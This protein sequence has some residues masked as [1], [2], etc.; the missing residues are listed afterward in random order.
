MNCTKHIAPTNPQIDFANVKQNDE[1]SYS[2]ILIRGT[3]SGYD[4]RQ[5][6]TDLFFSN[7][8]IQMRVTV[9]ITNDGHF[10]TIAKLT[11]GENEFI[12]NYCCTEKQIRIHFRK[13]T[14]S[15]FQLKIYYVICKNH[16]GNFQ[17]E[18]NISNTVQ[19]AIAKLDVMMSLIQCMYAELLVQNGF[20]R[21]TFD[22]VECVPFQSELTVEEARQWSPYQLWQYHAKEFLC[23]EL[24]RQK[25]YKYF[26]VLASTLYADG[27]LKGN[28]ALGIGDVALYGSGTMYSWPS[29]FER[30][31]E[32]FCDETL[33]DTEHLLD[34]SNGRKTYGGCFTT[35]LGAMCHEIGH[36]FDLGHTYN[37][38]MGND[39]DYVN[40]VFVTE[41]FPRNLPPRIQSACN[42][43]QVAHAKR[44][45]ERLTSLKRNNP[46]L[47]EY[48]NRRKNDLILMPENCAVLLNHHKW[49]NKQQP[50]DW[51]IEFV[52]KEK[53]EKIILSKLPLILIEFRSKS[54]GLC[55]E[56]HRFAEE[57]QQTEFIIQAN[58]LEKKFDLLAIDLNG[59]I[60]KFSIG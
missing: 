55:L 42:S 58:K 25:N 54:D 6:I 11:S 47:S 37:G 21:K 40:R 17:S 13:P 34:D 36:I 14:D 30:I 2:I 27:V 8:S 31:Q 53:E 4:H 43:H 29:K 56:Y 38:I 50:I 18:Q 60:R 41:R 19:S 28:A 7:Q 33:V 59:N 52:E 15:Q 32:C 46:I 1:F 5:G 44:T 20:N 24:D 51:A 12:F 57:Q 48:H 26:G 45:D 9:S 3:I 10:K 35:A 39:I 49:F 16:H 23:K 22:F